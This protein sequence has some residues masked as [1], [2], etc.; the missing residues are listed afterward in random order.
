MALKKDAV[1]ERNGFE[2]QLVAKDAY[3]KI[4]HLH[5]GKESMSVEICATVNGEQIE[6]FV[7]LFNPDLAGKNFIAQAYEHLKTLPEFSGATDC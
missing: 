2:G 5:G 1:F 6:R 4:N 3:W 7:S